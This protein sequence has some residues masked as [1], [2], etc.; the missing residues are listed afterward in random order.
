M[1]ISDVRLEN[2]NVLES[3]RTLGAFVD[4]CAVVS[5]QVIQQTSSVHEFA[6][7]THKIE[8]FVR[9]FR[10]E[11]IAKLENC[12]KLFLALVAGDFN[13]FPNFF[14][15]CKAFSPENRLD[16]LDIHLLLIFTRWKQSFLIGCDCPLDNFRFARYNE[17]CAIARELRQVFWQL[18]L[19]MIDHP[20][21]S[22]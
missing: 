6:T 20:S 21:A 9:M 19:D 3:F 14:I 15:E 8:F 5:V 18:V 13:E 16:F 11:V 2:F 4:F 17:L 10:L 1:N 7:T 22:A 12:L